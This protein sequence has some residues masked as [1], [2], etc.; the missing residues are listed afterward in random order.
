MS[1]ICYSLLNIPRVLTILI[2]D[3]P[4]TGIAFNSDLLKNLVNRMLAKKIIMPPAITVKV[5]MT[6]LTPKPVS[7]LYPKPTNTD[8]TAVAIN[9]LDIILNHL[10]LSPACLQTALILSIDAIP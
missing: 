10:I 6:L 1:L 4:I 8:I 5:A 9:G 3:D 2:R 7:V